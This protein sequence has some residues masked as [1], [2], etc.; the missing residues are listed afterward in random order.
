MLEWSADP[1]VRC[2]GE[3]WTRMP[4]EVVQLASRLLVGQLPHLEALLPLPRLATEE[5]ANQWQPLLLTRVDVWSGTRACRCGGTSEGIVRCVVA[6]E[7]HVR[8]AS[9]VRVELHCCNA[10]LSVE[11]TAC[12]ACSAVRK[13]DKSEGGDAIGPV[14]KTVC[15]A[16]RRVSLDRIAEGRRQETREMPLSRSGQSRHALRALCALCLKL[17][18]VSHDSTCEAARLA[19]V[20]ERLLTVWRR[21]IAPMP[22]AVRLPAADADAIRREL[23]QRLVRVAWPVRASERGTSA[24]GDGDAAEYVGDG[25][26]QWKFAYVQLDRGRLVWGTP[27][28]LASKETARQL[29]PHAALFPVVRVVRQRADPQVLWTEVWHDAESESI[30]VR[31]PAH[32]AAKATGKRRR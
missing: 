11:A 27:W 12:A 23:L 21:H 8:P 16:I 19:S 31:V 4:R 6:R 1:T 13:G 18:C 5:P 9:E 10:L 2:L 22:D 15:A 32:E 3:G 7:V 26:G 29:A 25:G 30:L 24:G 28:L 17:W 14:G 20:A